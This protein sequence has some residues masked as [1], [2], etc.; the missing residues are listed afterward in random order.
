[1]PVN[2]GKIH[3]HKRYYLH[4][5]KELKNNPINLNFPAFYK[6]A[7]ENIFPLSYTKFQMNINDDEKKVC[8]LFCINHHTNSMHD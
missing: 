6:I 8:Y 1:M 5:L 3:T 7:K 4:Y 2:D